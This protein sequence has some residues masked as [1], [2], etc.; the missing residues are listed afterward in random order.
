M[1]LPLLIFSLQLV[2]S[3]YFLVKTGNNRHQV[4]QYERGKNAERAR[5]YQTKRCQHE[6]YRWPYGWEDAWKKTEGQYAKRKD[7][8]ER[9][10]NYYIGTK[11]AQSVRL[12]CLDILCERHGNYYIGGKAAQSDIDPALQQSL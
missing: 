4:H 6:C 8:C 9:H 7:L 12:P 11:A 1:T 2:C 3:E 5:D 10:G